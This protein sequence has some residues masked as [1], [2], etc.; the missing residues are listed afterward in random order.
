MIRGFGGSSFGAAL[1]HIMELVTLP[2][3]T[4]KRIH[5]DKIRI[6]KKEDGPVITVQ[7]SKDP[8]K[9]HEVLIRGPSAIH[10]T[11]D[12]PLSCGAKAYIITNSEVHIFGAETKEDRKMASKD[13]TKVE[14]TQITNIKKLPTNS[15]NNAKKTTKKNSKTTK[16]AKSAKAAKTNSSSLRIGDK[17]AW[18]SAASGITKRK[19]GK[20]IAVVPPRAYPETIKKLKSTLNECRVQ[21]RNS[22]PKNE[23]S[24]IVRVTNNKGQDLVYRPNPNILKKVG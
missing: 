3:G 23:K 12:R 19:E 24:Y 14:K 13:K 5:I 6:Q 17:V 16:S 18:T 8:I 20:I 9:G 1:H 21:F 10:Y 4:M 15:K 7:T 11:P 22:S 2:S